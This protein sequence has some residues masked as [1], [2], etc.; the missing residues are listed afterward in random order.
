MTVYDDILFV[1]DQESNS[2]VTFNVTLNKFIRSVVQFGTSPA[3]T[4]EQI[5]LSEC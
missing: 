3:L 2:L 1:G 5:I 4:I